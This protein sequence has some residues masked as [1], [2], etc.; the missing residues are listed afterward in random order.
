MTFEEFKAIIDQN[1]MLTTHGFGVDDP[2]EYSF[3]VER[4]ALCDCYE[5]AQA[6]EEWLRLCTK[7]K[8]I[9]KRASTS[10][11]LKHRVER[12]M[13]NQHRQPDYIHEGAFVLAAIHLGFSMKQLRRLPNV[14]LN[15]GKMPKWE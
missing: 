4:N 11:S 15:I 14:Y 8:R 10:Y 9:D 7:R 5:D 2:L 1:P 6:C 12:W 13:F 3:E